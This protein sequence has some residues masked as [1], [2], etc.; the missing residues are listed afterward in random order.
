MFKALADR[1]AEAFA[2]CL[3]QRVR[4]DFWGYAA[5]ENLSNEQLIK[6]ST[7]ASAPRPATRPARTTRPR[8]TCSSAAGRRDRHGLTESLAMNPASSVSGF[9][10]GNPEASYFN[11]GQIGED[12]LADMAQRR[13]MDVEELRRFW[14]RIWAELLPERFPIKKSQ[15]M[16]WLFCG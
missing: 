6:E 1:L 14:R 7:R 3:H 5:D 15:G 4:K 9:Y 11:V 13:G 2:E 10:I 16:P 8:S 12:Q